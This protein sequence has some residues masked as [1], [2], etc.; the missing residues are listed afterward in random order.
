MSQP[1]IAYDLVLIDKNGEA[2]SSSVHKHY[3]HPSYHRFQTPQQL[4]R[5]DVIR[6]DKCF[7]EVDVIVIETNRRHKCIVYEIGKELPVPYVSRRERE[8]LP[9]ERRLRLHMKELWFE[10]DSFDRYRFSITK[11]RHSETPRLVSV[12]PV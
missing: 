2:S 5:G 7:Y 1:R 6:Y 11:S 8:L 12:S 10:N 3:P 4:K 9:H